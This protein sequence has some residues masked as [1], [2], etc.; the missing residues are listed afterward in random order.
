MRITLLIILTLFL[1]SFSE[2]Y[3]VNSSDID[4][5]S[6]YFVTDLLENVPNIR[7]HIFD[8][9]DVAIT[10]GGANSLYDNSVVY[11]VDGIV[12]RDFVD[13]KQLI[14][15]KLFQN[16]DI[17]KIEVVTGVD[18]YTFSNSAQA[19]INIVL[20]KN[21]DY[22]KTIESKVYIGS[23][24]GDPALLK[25]ILPADS[26]PYN[27]DQII[28]GEMGA[29]ARF[30]NTLLKGG[31]TIV[32]MDPYTNYLEAER[33]IPYPTINPNSEALDHKEGIFRHAF[34]KGD[35]SGEITASG[36]DY[37][38]FRYN[39]FEERYYHYSG[40]R[41][42]LR[43][44]H[45]LTKNKFSTSFVGSFFYDETE[46]LYSEDSAIDITSFGGTGRFSGNYQVSDS[47][48]FGASFMLNLD[49]NE[50][51]E[52]NLVKI[53]DT[54]PTIEFYGDMKFKDL[55]VRVHYP[56]GISTNLDINKTIRL[57]AAAIT[58]K[59]SRASE[60]S[61]EFGWNREFTPM[62]SSSATVSLKS[63]PNYKLVEDENIYTKEFEEDFRFIPTLTINNDNK[64]VGRGYLNISNYSGALGWV[65]EFDFFGLRILGGV[66]ASTPTYWTG[67]SP[68]TLGTEGDSI[69]KIDALILGRLLFSYAIWDD[70]LRFSLAFNKIGKKHKELPVGSMIGPAFVAN[71]ELNF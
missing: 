50:S 43:S 22:K 33:S 49:N 1:S 37:A 32:R 14:S 39:Q 64:I 58:P 31:F 13:G 57:S 17:E 16:L 67:L 12:L 40:T 42:E 19:V 6:F 71:I 46:M 7:T 30:E 54:L 61:G 65:K 26:I 11:A 66:E 3:T 28:A 29:N 24:I 48:E 41:A 68:E 15:S 2:I 20:K 52:E 34:D 53:E 35:M 8:G 69:T 18:V 36:G 63:T 70:K 23:E 44:N 60:F 21:S 45:R 9:V 27:K 55:L 62:N 38:I 47:L 59:G 4:K 25:E 56:F 5:N 10:S 51:I